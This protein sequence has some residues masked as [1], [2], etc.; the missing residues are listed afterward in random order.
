MA[1]SILKCSI[2]AEMLGKNPDNRVCPAGAEHGR[3]HHAALAQCPGTARP[4]GGGLGAVP[5]TGRE[6][7]E[8]SHFTQGQAQIITV[9]RRAC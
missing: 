7:P 8:Q 6:H 5:N 2:I 4:R 9:L 1:E 3:P